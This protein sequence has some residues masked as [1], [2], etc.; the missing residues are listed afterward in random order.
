M[1]FKYN[2]LMTRYIFQY[3]QLNGPLELNGLLNLSQ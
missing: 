2:R 1:F 3:P